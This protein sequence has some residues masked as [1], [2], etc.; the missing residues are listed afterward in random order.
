M[1]GQNIPEYIIRGIEKAIE[2]SKNCI[3]ED[4]NPRPKVGA[5]LIKDEYIIET[6]YRGEIEEGDH[7]EFTLLQKKTELT[8][9][10]DTILITT[11]EPCTSRSHLKLS[12]AEWIIR[13]GI[14]EVWIG[15]ED[16]NPD[17]TNRGAILLRDKGIAVERFPHK[18]VE[19][20]R[21]L[22]KPFWDFQMNKYRHDAMAIPQN[23]KVESKFKETIQEVGEKFRPYL[24]HCIDQED[25]IDCLGEKIPLVKDYNLF[26]FS[27]EA[28][29]ISE[30]R[31]L[32]NNIYY[33]SSSS[34]FNF[35]TFFK[36]LLK[37]NKRCVILRGSSGIGKSRLLKYLERFYASEMLTKEEAK[38]P[39]LI[40]LNYWSQRKS[41]FESFIEKIFN[42]ISITE[43]EL[44]SLLKENKFIILMDAFNEIKL[45]ERTDFL[46]D[47][48][49]FKDFSPDTNIIISMTPNTEFGFMDGD[50]TNLWM[51]PIKLENFKSL[52]E[53]LGLSLDFDEFLT[54]IKGY[55]LNELI[56]IPLFL[57]FSLVYLKNQQTLPSSKYEIIDNL[58]K[59]YFEVFLR[60]KY[61]FDSIIGSRPIWQ[62][63]LEKL[64]FYMHVKLEDNKIKSEDLLKLFSDSIENYNT[65]SLSYLKLHISDL[66]EFFINY[67]VLKFENDYYKFT[68]DILFEYYCGLRLA[69]IINNNK[70]LGI[71]RNIFHQYNLKNSLVIAF[72]LINNKKYIN[73]CKKRNKFIFI[74]GN[75]QK[76]L[77]TG[78][79]NTFAEEFLLKKIDTEY[80]YLQKLVYPLIITLLKFSNRK[81]DILIM[82]IEN[83]KAQRFK[84]E[85]LLKL[86]S[87]KSIKAKEYLLDF[88]GAQSSIR[89]RDVA[90]CAFD[91]K[92]TQEFLINELGSV[93]HGT[94]YPSMM[95]QGLLKL[96]KQDKLEE[97][98]FEEVLRLFISPPEKLKF[99]FQDRKEYKDAYSIAHSL[100]EGLRHI[101]IE[102][103]DPNI[104][105]QLIKVLDFEK[106][107]YRSIIDV[108]ERIL[109]EPNYRKIFT[110]VF[111]DD[112]DIKIKIPLIEVVKR[113]L[114]K[115]D[116]HHI[117]NFIE[118]IPNQ[119]EDRHLEI[120]YSDIIELLCIEERFINFNK[121]KVIEILRKIMYYGPIIQTSVV[122]VINKISPMYFF[123]DDNRI[124]PIYYR[125]YEEILNMIKNH[126]MEK[127][128][129]ILIENAK[130]CIP[131]WMQG[132]N[133]SFH[134]F[135]LFF[136][137]LD[138]LM[139][140]D[141]Y[142]EVKGLLG[143]FLN[144]IDNWENIN[145]VGFEILNKFENS[146]KMQF[147]KKIYNGYSQISK[148]EKNFSPSIFIGSIHP[149]ESD[150]FLDFNLQILKEHAISDDLLAEE[151][152][153]NL[154]HLNPVNNSREIFDVYT[155]GVHQRL[156]PPM[157]RLIST[158]M[159]K[160]SLK[161]NKRYLKSEDWLIKNTAFDE[162][163]KIYSKEN[164]LWYNNEE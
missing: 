16:P 111:N 55:N 76:D 2:I 20:I 126:K 153:R 109:D 92:A 160:K 112:L 99:N 105:P 48:T 22:C 157:L 5:V 108:I 1:S 50:L 85:A 45:E 47:L 87:L 19:Q 59:D 100:R 142:P 23:I 66:I 106:F 117:I 56:Q 95:G 164:E 71:K 102:R 138:V 36:E 43:A 63:T 4:E 25:Y 81:E 11:L 51:F 118:D 110:M 9:F 114:Y 33:Q 83:V 84:E 121:N 68:H 98:V 17:I 7:A 10:E 74:E 89:Y 37:E 88:K 93:W 80:F 96:Q 124:T 116:F 141:G 26:N 8:N 97:T 140:I 115:L 139:V 147:I 123:E 119:I 94:D 72:P 73:K 128:K 152:V 107:N 101:L 143:E 130:K 35:E 159:P 125:A 131:H 120:Y 75:L 42:Q 15:L 69:K 129:Q 150:E 151:V 148:E 154:I 30:K 162:I 38:I 6:A 145:H 41:I 70:K 79:E 82:I 62:E 146:D 135:F 18:Y 127:Y 61:T 49:H 27:L 132:A 104:I 57:N 60:R 34:Q 39:I 91:D 163:H 44:N 24:D 52:Y 21:V 46:K 40:D 29:D 32:F 113:A 13:S 133:K 12:C 14:K 67:N 103:N 137:I 64:S 54:H 136:K 3:N 158:I 149:F 161:I 134:N 31:F 144:Q 86:G 90:L 65:G 122:K 58:L 28:K 155:T 78:D 156:I 53:S 77:I